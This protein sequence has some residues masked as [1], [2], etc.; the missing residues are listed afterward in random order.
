MKA[1]IITAAIL[2]A[3]SPL[4]AE[5]K[6]KDP[7]DVKMEA[8]M[9]TNPSTAGMI[10]AAAAAMDSWKKDIGHSLAKLK[11]TMTPEEIHALELSQKAW[12]VFVETELATQTE[13]YSKM[14]GTMW[15]PASV[16]SAMGLYK[17]R[18]L[19]LRGYLETLS[20]R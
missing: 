4:H 8:A 20:E 9:D 5:D 1:Q 7:I 18:A 12:E 2:F 10:D 13:L 11:K 3:F 15:R 17:E 16:V 19:K 6:V 14:E